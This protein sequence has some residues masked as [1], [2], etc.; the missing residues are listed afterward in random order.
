MFTIA[1]RFCFQICFHPVAS[2][3]YFCCHFPQLC[4]CFTNDSFTVSL[5]TNQFNSLLCCKGD[6]ANGKNTPS[7]HQSKHSS[8]IIEG[9]IKRHNWE[10]YCTCIYQVSLSSRVSGFSWKTSVTLQ[11]NKKYVKTNT[12]CLLTMLSLYRSFTFGPGGP[13]MP[14]CPCLHL[15][16]ALPAVR[17]ISAYP[18]HCHGHK[19]KTTVWK[20][21]TPLT[22]GVKPCWMGADSPHRRVRSSPLN[23]PSLGHRTSP[24]AGGPPGERQEII[25]ERKVLS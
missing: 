23:K 18:P 17:P 11:K 24:F 14:G 16:E 5:T 13:W 7:K 2:Q 21:H 15:Q 10:T 22:K 3:L 6:A 20:L 25:W 8:S 4:C 19:G 9:S 1:K 12:T